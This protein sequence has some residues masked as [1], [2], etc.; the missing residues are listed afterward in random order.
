MTPRHRLIDTNGIRLH[1]A[2]LGGGPAVVLCHGWPETWYSWRHQLPAL[3][4]AGYR[5]IAPDMRGYGRSDRP[6]PIEAYTQLHIAGDMVGLL[7]ALEIPQAVIVGHD[8][9]A[10]AAWNSALMRPDRFRA[11][12]GLSVPYSPRGKISLIDAFKLG[13]AETIYMM[14]FQEPGV[15]EREF[16]RDIPT[17]LRRVLYSASGSLPG[18]ATWR[19]FVPPGRGLLDTT[20]DT[21]LP[22]PWLSEQD[23]AEYAKDFTASGFRG[24]FNWYR[25]LHRNWELMAAFA[26]A[27]ITQPS[28]FI[29]G[30]RDGVLRMPGMRTA[31]DNLKQVLPGLRHT[32]IIEGAG[33]W[34]QQ[35]AP[36]EVN[37][38]LIDFLKGL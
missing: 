24:G 14:Y 35:E 34:I 18:D 4:A 12:A 15:A 31:V 1:V 20:F 21:A 7:D 8:W 10:P 16:E 25:N 5:V 6:E 33:H 36:D 11:V 13:G 2:E 30:A 22:L 27:S 19:A 17:A 29:A 28:L 38:L 26:G 32:A 37:R 3:A 9:G 23:L